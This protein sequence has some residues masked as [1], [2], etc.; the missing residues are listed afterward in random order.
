MIVTEIL[1]FEWPLSFALKRDKERSSRD[2]YIGL[3]ELDYTTLIIGLQ[4]NV[5]RAHI[6]HV[7]RL[8]PENRLEAKEMQDLTHQTAFRPG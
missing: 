1:N 7:D 2:F 6:L 8:R 4:S 5:H 3:D